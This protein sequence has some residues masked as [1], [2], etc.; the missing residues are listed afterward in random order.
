MTVNQASTS[1][2]KESSSADA[3]QRGNS[4]DARRAGATSTYTTQVT[5][6]PF[7]GSAETKAPPRRSLF[8]M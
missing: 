5:E 3:N 4:A 6:L 8:R 1:H 7:R 2:P